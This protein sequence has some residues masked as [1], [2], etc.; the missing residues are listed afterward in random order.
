M[1]ACSRRAFFAF[2]DIGWVSSRYSISLSQLLAVQNIPLRYRRTG[3]FMIVVLAIHEI[4]KSI[5]VGFDS[6]L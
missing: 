1:R 2:D 6:L 3:P 4:V 5:P